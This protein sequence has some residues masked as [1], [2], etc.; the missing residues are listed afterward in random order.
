MA[1]TLVKEKVAK[2]IYGITP[3]MREEYRLKLEQLIRESNVKPFSAKDFDFPKDEETQAKIRA[4]V[5][6]FLQIH[7]QWRKEKIELC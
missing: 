7:E 5:D 1:E 2:N 3:E 6:E 4:E